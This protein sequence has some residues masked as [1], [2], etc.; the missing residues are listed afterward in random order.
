MSYALGRRCSLD[1]K[2]LWLWCRPATTAL[3]LPLAWEPPHAMGAA[4]P[5][6]IKNL[7]KFLKY[8]K[9]PFIPT[10]MMES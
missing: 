4:P 1:T 6:K 9:G 5:P 2:L 8:K 10:R 7:K 3:I